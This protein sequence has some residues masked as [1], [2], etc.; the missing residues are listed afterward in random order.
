MRIAELRG[1]SFVDA[2]D[3]NGLQVAVV[4]QAFANLFWP[5]E[6]PIGRRVIR[7]PD[8]SHPLTVI[9]VVGDVSDS[10]LALAPAPT[11]YIAW[12]QNNTGA[13]PVTLVVRSAGDPNASIRTVAQAVHR[14]DAALPFSQVTTLEAFLADSLGPDRFRSVLLL[15]FAGL[16]LAL[17]AVGIY[18]VTARGVSER[19]REL[20]VRLALGSGRAELWRLV[21]RRAL[22]AVAIGLGSSLPAAALTLRALSHWLPGVAAADPLSAVPAV[23]VLAVAG[24]LAAALPA[25]RAARLDPVIALRG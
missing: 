10:G 13:A 14:V 9:G 2:D 11:I 7:T 22:G 19:T 3:A 17:A 16:G 20:G 25:L 8:P 5:G 1:R 21:L 23:A 6:D 12:S 15:A 4:S 24:F 18:G